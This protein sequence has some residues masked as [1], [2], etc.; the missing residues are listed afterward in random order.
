LTNKL[1]N[2]ISVFEHQPLYASNSGGKNTIGVD[3]LIQLQTFHGNGIP[4]YSLINNGVRFCEYVGVIQIGNIV[5]EILPKTDK[6]KDKE[7]W[8]KMLINIL[9]AVGL[10]DVYAPTNADLSL[11]GNSILDLY[12]ALFLT[13][14]EQL[15]HNGLAKY[16]RQTE[17]NLSSLKGRLHFTKHVRQ[18]FIHQE[19]CYVRYTK[20]DFQHPLNLVL[21]KTIKLLEGVNTNPDLNSRIGNLLLN[22]P[23]LPDIN[24]NDDFFE[25]L[26]YNRKTERYKKAIDISRLLLLNY[27]PD[28]IRGRNNVLALMFDMNL[29]WERFVYVSLQQNKRRGVKV[30]PQPIKDFW[31]PK[32]GRKRIM[33]PDIV[34][35]S[36]T[37]GEGIVL[38]TKWKKPDGGNNPSPEDLRQLYTYSRFHQ[39]KYSALVYPGDK[40][41]YETGFFYDGLGKDSEYESGIMTIKC[42][43]EIRAWQKSI[44]DYVFKRFNIG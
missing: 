36:F 37:S 38:D 43:M 41:E 40:S 25:K 12:F 3:E 13:E 1:H 34:V 9:K 19:R 2:I 39:A 6:N 17:G 28:I 32:T 16:Y 35:T 18:N 15:F 10:F 14:V 24:I 42:E 21:Y 7:S 27:H 31:K 11:K 5:I 4:Y 23:E 33:K 8:R 44:A 29:L 30:E 22:F 26:T 20:Y